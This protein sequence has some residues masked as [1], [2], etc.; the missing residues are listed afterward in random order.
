MLIWEQS[1]LEKVMDELEIMNSNPFYNELFYGKGKVEPK[2]ILEE[3]QDIKP[4]RFRYVV[5]ENGKNAA[6]VEYLLNNPKDGKPWI[7]FLMVAKGYQKQGIA[8]KVYTACEQELR[9]MKLAALR[10]GILNGNSPAFSFWSR[11]GFSE[12]NIKESQGRKIH[13]FEKQL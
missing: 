7:G 9:K 5:K 13:I 8:R 3:L 12:I 6:I 4:P 10:L 1:G 2:D 11:M